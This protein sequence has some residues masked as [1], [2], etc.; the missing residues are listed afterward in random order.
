MMRA[1]RIFALPAV[2]ALLLGAGPM[3]ADNPS[4]P[5]Q[6]DW[7]PTTAMSLTTRDVGD[8]RVLVA[9]GM[10]DATLPARLR[11]AIEA[12]EMVGEVWLRSRGGDARA[13]NE[14]GRIIRSYTGMLTRIPAGWT[15]FS[16]CNFMFMGGDRRVVEPD[17]IFMVHMFTHTSDRSVISESVMDGTAATTELIAGIEQSS[18]ML[19]SEDNDFLIRMGIS[20]LLLTEV[21]YRQQAVQTE[22]N[23]STRYCLS[24]D[25]VRRYNVMPDE[26]RG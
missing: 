3:D 19:A 26:A 6:P 23:A 8:Y 21:M 9:D 1:F 25:E 22:G 4:C 2:A 20:R 12:D 24:Q 13:G 17:G 5:A 15:C 10:I 11:A 7:G 18:A 16:A 14:A